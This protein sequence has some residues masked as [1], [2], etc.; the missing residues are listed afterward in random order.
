MNW[1]E[2]TNEIMADVVK[3]MSVEDQ[4]KTVRKYVREIER[5][6]DPAVVALAYSISEYQLERVAAEIWFAKNAR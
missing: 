3:L 1:K 2:L 6:A 4:I 5:S